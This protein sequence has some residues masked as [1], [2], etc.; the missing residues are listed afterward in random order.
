MIVVRCKKDEKNDENKIAK[1]YCY[2][3]ESITKDINV[4]FTLYRGYY[5]I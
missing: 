2:D 1:Y 4:T 5:V 3:V